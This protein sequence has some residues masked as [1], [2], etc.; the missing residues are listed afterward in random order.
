MASATAAPSMMAPSTMLSGGTGSAANADDAK[1]LPA[2]LS[3]TALTALDPMSRPTT[4]FDLVK[5]KHVRC[6]VYA[7]RYCKPAMRKADTRLLW[8]KYRAKSA[9]RTRIGCRLMDNSRFR[10]SRLQISL[11]LKVATQV[12][13]RPTT[14]EPVISR[15]GSRPM[16]AAM[17]ERRGTTA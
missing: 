15:V 3:S 7:T 14:H 4:A 8:D 1:P 10:R 9:A 16:S 17:H 5:T 6:P 13:L 11:E 12:R 2:G